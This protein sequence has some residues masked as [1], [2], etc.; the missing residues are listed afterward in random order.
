MIA[1]CALGVSTKKVCSSRQL[2]VDGDGKRSFR[3]KKVARGSG[4]QII[5]RNLS[6]WFEC[7]AE[8]WLS[9]PLQKNWLIAVP[10]HCQN[11][12]GEGI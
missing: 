2:S 8:A 10:V 11:Y 12:S 3:R 4:G 7:L 1:G 6:E 9:A 5:W